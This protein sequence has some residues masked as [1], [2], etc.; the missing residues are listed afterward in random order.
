MSR[1]PA[2][3]KIL[4]V[5]TA[6][7]GLGVAGVGIAAATTTPAAPRPHV[8]VAAAARTITGGTRRRSG[9]GTRPGALPNRCD[10]PEP[11]DSPRS[12]RP[13]DASPEAT[14]PQTPPKLATI[15]NP[16]RSTSPDDSP[17]V[18]GPGADRGRG[19]TVR[20]SGTLRCCPAGLH[21][22]RRQ[23]SQ[24]VAHPPH[25]RD[26]V[27]A[28]LAAQVADVDVDDVGA[29][30]EVVAPHWLSSCS[31]DSTW[32]GCRR[33]VSARA[34]SRADRSTVRPPTCARRVRRSS[35]R[36]P[37][38]QH[39]DSAARSPRSRSRTRASSSSKRNGLGM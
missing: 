6:L 5:G 39:G 38:V 31:R 14:P 23:A 11:A 19:A 29:G 34:N 20:R 9:P 16:T 37:L 27:R 12:R 26:P 1:R 33:N 15:I 7:T 25:G 4:T 17:D 36:P 24:P 30:V 3:W 22:G 32:P 10:S 28:E 2:T 18:V 13:V 8:T 35:D 21:G